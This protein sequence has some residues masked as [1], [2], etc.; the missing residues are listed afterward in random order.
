MQILIIDT[1]VDELIDRRDRIK[2]D[3]RANRWSC[4]GI[5]WNCDV[6]FYVV[7]PD[8]HL[9]PVVAALNIT[10]ADLLE[11]T[12]ED[13]GTVTGRVHPAV[14]H[15]LRTAVA[16]GNILTGGT[17]SDAELLHHVKR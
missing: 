9:R 1:E 11:A 8:E 7:L 5:I 3:H 10:H 16:H 13:V 12:V 4:D 15:A 6:S 2:K 14:N 17:V